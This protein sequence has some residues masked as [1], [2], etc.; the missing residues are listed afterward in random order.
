MLAAVGTKVKRFVTAT[1]PPTVSKQIPV[2]QDLGESDQIDRLLRCSRDR[3]ACCRSSGAPG[4]RNI[5]S[6]MRLDRF[7]R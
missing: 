1:A 5:L 4:C 2:A 7:R 3:P 6:L